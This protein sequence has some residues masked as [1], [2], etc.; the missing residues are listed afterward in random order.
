M[1]RSCLAFLLFGQL[2]FGQINTTSGSV[3]TTAGLG[4]NVPPDQVTFTVTIE[5]GLSL[6]FNDLIAALKGSGLSAT[7]F[8][9]V[10]SN[11]QYSSTS[12]RPFTVLEWNFQ[13]VA[14]LSGVK[15][16]TAVLKRL[17]TS[18]KPLTLT[19]SAQALTS[20]QAQIQACAVSDLVSSARTQAQQLAAAANLVPGNVAAMATYISTR[21][22]PTAPIPYVVPACSLTMTFGGGQNS[23]RTLTVSA[24]RTINVTPDQVTLA[25]YVDTTVDGTLDDAVAALAGTGFTGANLLN[26]SPLYSQSGNEWQFSATVPLAKIIDSLAALQKA[27]NGVSGTAGV[28]TAVSFAVQGTQVSSD[29]AAAQDCTKPA[30][31]ADAQ[32]YARRVAAAA[33]L[34]LNGILAISDGAAQGSGAVGAFTALNTVRSGD[35]SLVSSF[36]TSPQPSCSVTVQFGIGQ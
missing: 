25:A 33:G 34:S 1:L 6:S 35:F 24:S 12:N 31:V 4:Q 9:N 3:T 21:I 23:Q 7:N 17:Q 11:Q 22:G 15:A 30:L 16:E 20:T 32:A 8:T 26:V 14:P 27:Q 13:V 19:Y 2:V 18:L 29:L 5:S 28:V 36:L 10:Y